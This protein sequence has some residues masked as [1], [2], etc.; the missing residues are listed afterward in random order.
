MYLPTRLDPAE[1]CHTCLAT[2]D[3]GPR[4]GLQA[5]SFYTG[6]GGPGTSL[7]SSGNIFEYNILSDL[8]RL[9]TDGGAIEMIGSGNPNDI[10][11]QPWWNNNTIRCKCARTLLHNYVHLSIYR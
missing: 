7:I 10:S 5:D 4:Y 3:K 8:C 11:G 9:T 2:T 1:A 6:E